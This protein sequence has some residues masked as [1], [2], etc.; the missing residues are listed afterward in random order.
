MKNRVSSEVEESV[1]AIATD[2]PAFG[3]KQAANELAKKGV[4]ISDGGVE[5][6]VFLPTYSLEDLG[7]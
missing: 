3:Q 1:I 5:L 7:I 4:I 2:N 6:F